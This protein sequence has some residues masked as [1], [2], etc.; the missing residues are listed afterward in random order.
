MATS[1]PPPVITDTGYEMPE[2]ATI[3]AAVLS[4]ID[5]AFGGGLNQELST[6]QGQLASSL[7]AI[8]ADKD[9]CF[10]S[11]VNQI[12][13]QYAQGRMQD[14]IASLYFLS[15][16]PAR[17]T[18]VICTCTGLENTVIPATTALAKDTAG[19]I[20]A[21]TVGGTI[22]ATG[23]IEL[24]FYNVVPGPTAC[25]AGTLTAI[26]GS[27]P[28]WD[29]ITN[30]A[31]GALG[32]AVE[33]SQEFEARR[34]ASVSINSLGSISSIY[35]AVAASGADLD[36]PNIPLDVYVVDNRNDIATEVGG[37][38]L[39]PHSV[40]VAAAGG[41]PDSIGMAIWKK[42]SV[43]CNF[44]G[45]TTVVIEDT[46]GYDAPYPTYTV[47]YQVPDDYAIKF[48]VS[49]AS[50]PSL[51]ANIVTL[52]K[53]AIV[54][55]FAGLDGGSRARIGADIYASR[56]YYPVSTCATGVAIVSILVGHTTATANSVAV[57]IDQYPTLTVSDITVFLV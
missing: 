11:Y 24:E 17:S 23:S 41:D 54:D 46:S 44:N 26:Y 42:T 20:Y 53:N 35:G 1:V 32:N 30:A 47:K 13:P 2:E 38:T 39:L 29:T 40:Y 37:V 3:L 9:R 25:P 28:G 4:D 57:N 50:S 22:D 27:I 56:F 6:P 31:D 18:T 21:C 12:D 34:Y 51:P 15:R 33:T 43:G 5:A 16:I 19:N 48:R 49:I 36:P 7:A 14:A 52:V 10:L 8:I 45:D 55:A